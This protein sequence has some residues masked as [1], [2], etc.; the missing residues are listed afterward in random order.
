MFNKTNTTKDRII[1]E[2]INIIL[3]KGIESTSIS[4]II[5]AT[6]IARG[7]LY[8]HFPDKEALMSEAIKKYEQRFVEFLNNALAGKTPGEKIYNFLDSAF[9]I[10]VNRNFQGGCIFGNTAL[11]MADKN[12]VFRELVNKVFE[13]W[14]KT[15]STVIKEAQNT[16]EVRNDINPD[17]L[18]CFIVA[19][20]EGGI[21]LSKVKKDENPLSKVIL[22]L[23]KSLKE[24]ATSK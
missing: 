23:K 12:Y 21:M 20:V 8:H 4:D 2:T 24:N 6:G 18:A 3:L 17:D 1:N 5:K 14:A 9:K 10:H 7:S 16:G 13:E 22:L 15:L 11:E 19:S